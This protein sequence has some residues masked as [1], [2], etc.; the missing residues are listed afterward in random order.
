MVRKKSNQIPT[1]NLIV[2]WGAYYQSLFSLPNIM[3]EFGFD[4]CC[5]LIVHSQKLSEL[6][7]LIYDYHCYVMFLLLFIDF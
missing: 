4:D 6:S 7:V 5:H 2:Y 1:G 3:Y